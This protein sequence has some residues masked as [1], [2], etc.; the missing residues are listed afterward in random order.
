M[1]GNYEN[2][3]NSFSYIY[4]VH[5]VSFPRSCLIGCKLKNEYASCIKKNTKINLSVRQRCTCTLILY[6]LFKK[7]KS[8]ESSFLIMINDKLL[9][10]Y[11]LW[12]VVQSNFGSMNIVCASLSTVKYKHFQAFIVLFKSYL[13]MF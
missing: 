10:E 4:N 13:S 9:V 1:L 6:L 12:I 11:S 3:L 8:G 5:T 7:N 2:V